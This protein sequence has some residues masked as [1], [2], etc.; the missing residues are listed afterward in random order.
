MIIPVDKQDLKRLFAVAEMESQ[1]DDI[2]AK[3]NLS[4]EEPRDLNNPGDDKLTTN[5]VSL[6]FNN[7]IIT[8]TNGKGE[9][10]KHGDSEPC[11]SFRFK[12][13]F[14]DLSEAESDKLARIVSKVELPVLD[15]SNNE[16]TQ[17]KISFYNVTWPNGQ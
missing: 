12:V 5:T 10:I 17:V 2:I 3:Y 6:N 7:V 4:E 9:P 15:Y 1:C 14:P 8:M 16:L 13:S 11:R